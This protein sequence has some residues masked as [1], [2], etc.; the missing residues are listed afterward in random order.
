M[1]QNIDVHLL[2]KASGGALWHLS[3]DER[4]E[5]SDAVLSPVIDEL[6]AFECR[7]RKTAKVFHVT[8]TPMSRVRFLAAL[9]LSCREHAIQAGFT[10]LISLPQR[11]LGQRRKEPHPAA[12]V[13]T[14]RR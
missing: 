11:R 9:R 7:R 1:S 3:P 2:L 4:E 6:L 12:R 13:R 10:L 5:T 8:R 14:L